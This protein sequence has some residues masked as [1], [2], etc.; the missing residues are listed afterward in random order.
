MAART[1]DQERFR[2]AAPNYYAALLALG[3]TDT[4]RAGRLGVIPRQFR[5]YKAGRSFPQAHILK[6]VPELDAA[7]TQ[8][9]AAI[10]P[11][12]RR[13][14]GGAQTLEPVVA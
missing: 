7:Y 6:S 2:Q 9:F 14:E 13:R 11:F 5:E 10:L 1:D 3:N 4:E 12:V 8:D